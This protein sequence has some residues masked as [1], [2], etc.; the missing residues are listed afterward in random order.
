MKNKELIIQKIK[1]KWKIK[2]NLIIS[3]LMT[4]LINF[5][6]TIFK[7]ISFKN[8]EIF[9]FFLQNNKNILIKK[10]EM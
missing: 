2:K 8:Y 7:K 1:K 6:K 4:S 5:K 9:F 3:F 10:K